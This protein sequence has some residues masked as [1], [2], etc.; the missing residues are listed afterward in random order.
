MEQVYY[1]VLYLLT[2]HDQTNN[3][4]TP[5][6]GVLRKFGAHDWK[7]KCFSTSIQTQ[8]LQAL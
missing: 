1:M 5:R 6:K 3:M 8:Q 4:R 7:V 2:A